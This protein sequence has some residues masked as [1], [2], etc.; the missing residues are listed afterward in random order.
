L[1]GCGGALQEKYIVSSARILGEGASVSQLARLSVKGVDVA[2]RPDNA[3]PID[4]SV[5]TIPLEYRFAAAYSDN[6]LLALDAHDPFVIEVLFSTQGHE[7][8]FDPMAIELQTERGDK[9]RPIKAY[10]LVPRYPTTRSLNPAIPL[11]RRPDTPS[12][13]LGFSPLS[14]YEIKSLGPVHLA[15]GKLYCFAVAFGI[16]RVD[17]R[18]MFT[19]SLKDM[20]V[21]GSKISVPAISFSAGVYTLY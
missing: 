15:R 4:R 1:V 6:Y 2:V 14:I 10:S 18:A 9:S 16:P 19:L 20:D 13:H 17:P 12:A 3:I 7:V 5:G 21:R 11:C 8:G